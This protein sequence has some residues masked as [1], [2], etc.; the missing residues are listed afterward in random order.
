[1]ARRSASL[2]A[3]DKLVTLTMTKIRAFP[4]A[5]SRQ[6]RS[7]ECAL[8]GATDPL[9]ITALRRDATRSVARTSPAY[10]GSCG[11]PRILVR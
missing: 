9:V 11:S 5:V 4:D 8:D 10:I 7:E 2:I 3:P 6:P 1:M